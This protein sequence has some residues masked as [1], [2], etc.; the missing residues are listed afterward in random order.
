MARAFLRSLYRAKLGFRLGFLGD[1]D[2]LPVGAL[3]RLVRD[4]L[5]PEDQP[6]GRAQAWEF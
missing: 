4:R 5:G 6:R 2:Q 1:L 3:G